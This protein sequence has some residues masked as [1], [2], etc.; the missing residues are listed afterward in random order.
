[1]KNIVNEDVSHNFLKN[2]VNE[3]WVLNRGSKEIIFNQRVAYANNILNTLQHTSSRRNTQGTAILARF[4]KYLKRKNTMSQGQSSKNLQKKT[5]T[6][7]K[8]QKEG[9]K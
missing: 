5:K 7:N 4:M 2:V 8:K 3:S 1:M 6:K 9:K